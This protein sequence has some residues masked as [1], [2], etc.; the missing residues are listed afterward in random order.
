M[1]KSLSNLL[2]IFLA[3]LMLFVG[4][5]Q[6]EASTQDMRIILDKETR[7][8]TPS[9]LDLS[10]S[11][12]KITCV[13]PDN[14]THV[15]NTRRSTFLLEG[16][17][18]GSWNITAEG[19]ND[20]GTSLV[21][22]STN[23]NLN[24]TNTS[25]VVVLNQLIGQGALNLIYTWPGSDVEV[26]SVEVSIEDQNGNIFLSARNLDISNS[27]ATLSVNELPAG[28][29]IVHAFLYNKGK[30][31]A[32]YTEA[33]R[34]AD[35]RTTS[36]S[37]N[38]NVTALPD[39]V[40][41]LTLEN[42]A[43]TPVI[44]TVKNI[45]SGDQ[46]PAQTDL[47]VELDTSSINS[48]DITVTWYLDGIK[49]GTGTE[50]TI[51]PAPGE[52]RL[53]IIAA[54]KMLGTTGSTSISFQAAI[55]G[56]VGVPVLAGVTTSS[57]ELKIGGRNT[58]EFL[59]DGNILLT[60]DATKTAT[61]CS[62]QLNEL[63]ANTSTTYEYPVC[64]AIQLNGYNKIVLLYE[65]AVVDGTTRGATARYAYD[66]SAM[67]LTKEVSGDGL[68]RSNN[69]DYYIVKPVGLIK[70]ANWMNGNFGF[71]GYSNQPRNFIPLRSIE[72]SNTTLGSADCYYTTGRVIHGGKTVTQ[73]TLMDSSD[74]G[75][76]SVFVN[77]TDGYIDFIWSEA[78]ICRSL[79]LD[80]ATELIGATAVS[81]LPAGNGEISRAVVTVGQ[82]LFVYAC[83]GESI[84][85]VRTIVRSSDE[86]SNVS[87][88]KM[89]MNYDESFLY[90]FNEQSIST[91]KIEN[92]LPVFVGVT[93]TNFAPERVAISRSGA[94]LLCCAADS[95]TIS[96]FRIKTN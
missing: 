36:G 61:I 64:D 28:S 41:Q 70:N 40:G 19:C 8:I 37:L 5:S 88:V 89:L 35:G 17:P 38:F 91:W 87:S 63:V 27:S 34:I 62:I 15:Y 43:G 86:G 71:F 1:K 53:D 92:N 18:V 57:E 96:M 66:G 59:S 56:E 45:S 42:K 85:K 29:Y 20:E 49:I 77:P 32:G 44:C 50:I 25:A 10:I 7:T 2:L 94:Y 95:N 68:I 30:K 51:C 3:S 54:T 55:L 6:E 93:K 47:K 23:F 69:S 79:F 65:N 67:T 26:P 73:Y 74:D 75:E 11:S 24:K 58:M 52:H 83:D 72:N 12:Y 82:N 81:L 90:I 46:V 48:S 76:K 33:V 13:G 9:N 78:N 31:V 22:G 4:C 16:V 39:V 60:S 84:T 14:K 80:D 21:K